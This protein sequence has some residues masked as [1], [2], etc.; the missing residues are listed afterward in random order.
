MADPL[1]ITASLLA[2]TTAALQSTKSLYETVKRFKGRDKTLRRLQ[3]ELEDLTRILDSLA[4]VTNAEQSMF[5]LLQGPI[6]RCSQICREFEKSMEVFGGKSKPPGFRDWTKM[7]FMRGDMNEFIDTIA[8]YKSTISV[9][10]GT[11]TMMHTSKISQQVLQNFNERIQDTEYDL[12]LHLR[13][14]EQKMTRFEDTENPNASGASIDLEDEREVTKQCLRICEGAKS[15]IESL[16]DRESS[17]L[18]KTPAA[19]AV[20]TNVFEAQLRTRKAL[21]EYRDGF[22]ETIGYLQQRLAFLIQNDSPANENE[23]SRFL[24]DIDVSKKCL[25]VCKVASEVSRQTIFRIGEVIAED[26]SDQVVVTNLADLFDVRKALSK[27]GSAQ[28]VGSMTAE[29]LH[30][31]TE[32]RYSSRFGTLASHPDPA[33]AEVGTTKSSGGVEVQHGQHTTELK[34]GDHEQRPGS[35]TRQTRPSPNEMRKRSMEETLDK[36][37]K[38]SHP[39]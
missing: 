29:N 36:C 31:L 34:P 7:E 19:D 11:V 21:D 16:S 6:E 12:E 8:R 25:E 2:V 37:S 9:G 30:H 5:A 3:D 1:S 23:R 27:H 13:R 32:K 35:R 26:S 39:R 22:T 15:Y 10:I 17:V 24:A 20:E 33:A 38:E 18:P 14:I 4:Q 28:L